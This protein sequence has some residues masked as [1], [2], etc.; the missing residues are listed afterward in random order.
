MTKCELFPCSNNIYGYCRVDIAYIQRDGTCSEENVPASDIP[1][2]LENERVDEL[3]L[4]IYE[5]EGELRDAEVRRE[6]L[7][8][9][10]KGSLNFKH[11]SIGCLIEDL[12]HIIDE[13]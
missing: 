6:A 5:V 9:E 12:N 13:S 1:E 7:L 2:L 4:E 10:I 3:E 8:K 11:D